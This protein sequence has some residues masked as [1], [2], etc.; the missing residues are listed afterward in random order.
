M[1]NKKSKTNIIFNIVA[2]VGALV[3]AIGLFLNIY[4]GRKI[5]EFKSLVSVS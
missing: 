4:T 5:N 3:A 2:L 1:A